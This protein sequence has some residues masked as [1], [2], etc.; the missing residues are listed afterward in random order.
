MVSPKVG[1]LVHLTPSLATYGNVSRGFRSPDGII[2]EPS[3]VPIT[4]TAYEVGLK[5]DRGLFHASAALFR[6][7]VSDEQTFNPVTLESSNGG[8]SR[9]QGVEL[10]WRTAPLAQVAILSGQ[11]TFN[12][13]R[14]TS[15]TAV[16]EDGDGPPETLNGLR[17]YNT[18]KFIGTVALDLTHPASPWRVRM[19][20][21]LVGPYSPFDQPGVVTGGYGLANLM[22]GWTRRQ[23]EVDVGMRN[24]FDRAYPELIAGEVV[25]PGEPRRFVVTVRT[26]R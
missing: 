24:V 12:D 15:L 6:M 19:S 20:T 1:A 21:N 14:Y 10:E 4:A 9:R 8:S 11:W 18:S 2:G 16:P 7:D 17:V 23:L 5:T 3:L 25:A 13:A 26:G 22:L